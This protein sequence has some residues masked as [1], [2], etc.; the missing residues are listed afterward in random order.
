MSESQKQ[1]DPRRI[2]AYFFI[3]ADGHCHGAAR[4][5]ATMLLNFYNG[6]RFQF[7]LTDLRLLDERHLT[8]ALT[9]MRFDAQLSREVHEHL[10]HMYSRTDFG[11]RFE[12]LAHKWSLK[13]KCLKS[14]LSKVPPV[15]L[16]DPF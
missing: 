15:T 4:I 16:A 1:Q 3:L 2:L 13:G 9:L 11:P 8:M 14:H 6:H 12:H 10:N 5:A 7:D